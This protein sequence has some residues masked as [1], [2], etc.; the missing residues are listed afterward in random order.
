MK[1]FLLRTCFEKSHVLPR[2]GLLQ[3][4]LLGLRYKLSKA[5]VLEK[6]QGAQRSLVMKSWVPS[7]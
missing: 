3:T 6:L 1:S 5:V 2:N 4:T 7:I